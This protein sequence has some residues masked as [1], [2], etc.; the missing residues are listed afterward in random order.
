MRSRSIIVGLC[1]LAAL[2]LFLFVSR[3]A[4]DEKSV[5]VQR[6]TTTQR[7]QS[8]VSERGATNESQSPRD[9]GIEDSFAVQA[10]DLKKQAT[11]GFAT[12]LS[13]LQPYGATGPIKQ[14]YSQFRTNRE[15]GI[16]IE[17]GVASDTHYASF[18]AGPVDAKGKH[19]NPSLPS[20]ALLRSFYSLHDSSDTRR[21]PEAM[22]SWYKSTGTWSEVEAVSETFR[23][24]QRL[25][26]PTNQVVR[27][28]YEPSTLTVQ[29]PD[30]SKVRVTPFHT[31]AMCKSSDDDYS[32]FLELE[33]R[34]D[35]KPPGR[36]TRWHSWPPVK[37]P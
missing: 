18:G 13:T 8:Q 34:I 10:E 30:G 28:R 32:S 1:L 12:L 36:V 25:G 23:L 29:T 37:V 4:A 7:Q 26:I 16:N 2:A 15:G 17:I 20:G 33:Y 27:Y 22:S 24:M 3:K 31:V 19:I 11:N 5:A 9:P 14:T 35:E 21:N 6:S